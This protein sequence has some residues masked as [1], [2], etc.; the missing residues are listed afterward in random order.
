MADMGNKQAETTGATE[1]SGIYLIKT[2]YYKNFVELLSW[3]GFRLGG[4]EA[5]IRQS[6][7]S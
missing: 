1:G 4:G 2:V 5:S 3:Y 7:D 6:R